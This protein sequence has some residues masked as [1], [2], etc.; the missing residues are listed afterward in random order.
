VSTKVKRHNPIQSSN[1]SQI[2]I[3]GKLNILIIINKKINFKMIKNLHL[4]VR[5]ILSLNNILWEESKIIS[6][7]VMKI[8][9]NF[10][11]EE[12]QEDKLLRCFQNYCIISRV[13]PEAFSTDFDK[14]D[15]LNVWWR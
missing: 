4:L 11:V 5:I 2:R 13:H 6:G 15:D 1:S 7:K 10:G 12:T 3:L 14:I 9:K 8:L